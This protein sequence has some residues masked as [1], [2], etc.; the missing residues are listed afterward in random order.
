PSFTGDE[1]LALAEPL[2]VRRVVLIQ[3]H[4]YHG[5]DNTYLIDETA[6]HPGRFRVVGMVDDLNA[7]ADRQMRE[8]LPKKVTGFRITPFIHGADKWLETPGMAGMW[9]CAAETRQA[10]CCLIDASHLEQIDRMCTR[11]P[12][13]PVVIDHF[14]RIGMDGEIR[15]EDVRRLAGLARHPQVRVKVS[16]FYALGKKQPPH[17]ELL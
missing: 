6:R 2:G 17:R 4:I 8:L 14:A 12:E 5:Y 13:T 11:Y 10:I 1:L 16:A 9:R 3:H 15:D 7:D